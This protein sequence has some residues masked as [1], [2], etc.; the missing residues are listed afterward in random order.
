MAIRRSPDFRF[1]YYLR[2]LPTD[3][4]G[5]RCEQLMKAAEKEVE[6]LIKKYSSTNNT[7]V[8]GDKETSSEEV[9]LPRYK[10]MR[11]I[12]RQQQEKLIEMETRQL[13]GRVEDIETKMEEIQ[14]RLKFL[15][16][17]S[18]QMEGSSG[19]RRSSNQSSEFPEELLSDLANL[20]ATSGYAGVASIA[21]DFIS[22]HGQICSKKSLCAK[23][24]DIAKKERRKDEGNTR[25]VWY[26]LPEY[27]SLLSVKTIRK[28]RAS[29]DNGKKK[30]GVK[31][32][33]IDNGKASHEA[34]L[35]EGAMGP[36][37]D[38]IEFPK[39]D[40]M[41]EPR[42]CKKAFT[43]FCTG[44]KKEVK[45]SLDLA[46]RKDKVSWNTWIRYLNKH[47][48]AIANIQFFSP[49]KNPW[50][51]ETK[52]ARFISKRKECLEE[53]GSMGQIA[54]RERLHCL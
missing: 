54:L 50:I 16:K 45:K 11:E 13:E 5:K 10:E 21:N 24:E 33:K 27:T 32:E 17:C 43:L 8:G 34:K 20:I 19:N 46:S 51:I 41:E 15:Q 49:G 7:T 14:N 23:I 4:I 26:I 29:R 53:M 28:L 30:T 18:N 40:C 2:S 36:D 6:H 3:G 48:F 47:Y 1:D 39:Y 25:P 44:T 42:I 9:Q 22:K 31:R 37:G 35:T 52:M 12:Q 38:I